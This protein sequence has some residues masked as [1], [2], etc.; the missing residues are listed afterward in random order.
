[1]AQ[2][3]RVL[4][5]D[6]EL[7][8]DVEGLAD[9]YI[10]RMLLAGQLYEAANLRYIRSLA[11]PFGSVYID[12]GAFIGTHTV[13]FGRCC[14][15]REVYA[16]E[17]N[18]RAFVLLTENIALNSISATAISL[19]LGQTRSATASI[20][21]VPAGN[22]GGARL[23]SS[24]GTIG[25]TTLDEAFNGVQCDVM[26]IDVEGAELRCPSRCRCHASTL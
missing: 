13:F 19:G 15:A 3:S 5:D 4:I 1:M 24:G 26:K 8:F 2:I 12:I 7:V 21:C 18:P 10:G 6:I 14:G 25:A 11:I 23:A 22:L 16:F 20:T 9:D 17:P